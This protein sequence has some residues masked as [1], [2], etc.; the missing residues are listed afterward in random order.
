MR[1]FAQTGRNSASQD[2]AFGCRQD[3]LGSVL[4]VVLILVVLLSLAAYR[5]TQLMISE[6]QS[7]GHFGVLLQTRSASESGIN[8][9]IALLHQQRQAGTLS[10][11][12]ANS[13]SKFK[14]KRIGGS[15]YEFTVLSTTRDS[16]RYGLIDESTRIN[17]NAIATSPAEHIRTQNSV[18]ALERVPGMTKQLAASI[19]DC[20]DAD[21]IERVKGSEAHSLN[22]P[23]TDLSEL[24]RIPGVTSD[25]LIGDWSDLL[26]L[27]SAESNTDRFGKPRIYLNSSVESLYT[28]LQRH[29]SIATRLAKF[30]VAWRLYGPAGSTLLEVERSDPTVAGMYVPPDG[31]TYPLTVVSDLI[32]AT[33]HVPVPNTDDLEDEDDLC[34]QHV[35]LESPL[36]STSSAET[37]EKALDSLTTSMSQRLIGRINISA[38]PRDVLMSVP[39]MNDE[40]ASRILAARPTAAVR[41][42]L[43]WYINGK[44]IPLADFRKFEPYITSVGHV[45]SA[46]SLGHSDSNPIR[47][48]TRAVID[49]SQQTPRTVDWQEFRPTIGLLSRANLELAPT[50]P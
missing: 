5:Y 14:A 24:M 49:V 15:G 37:L 50:V 40:I 25:L 16:V 41:R 11:N 8:T 21:N 22:R 47:L 4:L 48:A 18:A 32:D 30:V 12:L 19:L 35:V 34:C 13:E 44:H 2:R 3:R 28:Q 33:V 29:N 31:R 17:I 23:L 10:G 38:A 39:S 45:Y 7:A 9:A 6:H 20:I 1:S 43:A 46:T 36:R 42:G 27:H 26:T